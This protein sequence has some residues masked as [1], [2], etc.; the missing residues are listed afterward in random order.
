[1]IGL[2]DRDVFLKLCCCNLWWE[3]VAALEITQPFRLA[4]TSSERS[5]RRKITQMLGDVDLEET[6]QRT[7]EI[8]EAVPVLS[9]ELIDQI[10]ATEGYQELSGIDGIDGGE[11][12]L[13]AVLI[14]DPEGRVLLSG[15]KRFVQAF[16]DNLPEK[17]RRLSA[18][19]IS[20]EK[21]LLAIEE[22]HGFDYLL[23]HVQPVRQ[24]DGSLRIAIGH[25]PSS[26]V[27]RAAMT[28][29]DPCRVADVVDV[30]AEVIVEEIDVF[31]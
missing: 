17:W 31:K 18:S 21:C 25:Q 15:D 24:C 11:Q 12:I 13:A 19:I 30:V 20:F 14:N 16:R 26:E 28:S 27:F 6:I 22:R 8:V 5:N 10:Y 4:A 23:Q 29:F 9:D 3:A 1:M 7:Q 2:F